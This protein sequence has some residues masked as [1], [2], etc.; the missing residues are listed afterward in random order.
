MCTNE[1]MTCHLQQC[2]SLVFVVLLGSIRFGM[3]FLQKTDGPFFL[4][5]HD[6]STR[7]KA[8]A[9]SLKTPDSGLGPGL[10]ETAPSSFYHHA[11]QVAIGKRF[12]C[13]SRAC[14]C[15]A[16]L[17]HSH[18]GA[19]LGKAGASDYYFPAASM[20]RMRYKNAAVC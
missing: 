20:Q 4:K 11:P 7:V 12:C 18:N 3:L 9:R 16:E 2:H 15:Q 13:W 17:A 14:S 6:V 19:L 1:P 10:Y 5:E 8:M